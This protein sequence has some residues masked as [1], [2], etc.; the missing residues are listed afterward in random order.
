MTK[1]NKTY[2]CI[3]DSMK[4][5]FGTSGATQQILPLS[6]LC[7]TGKFTICK[8]T[9]DRKLCAR[10]VA[11]GIYPGAEG[12]LICP[13]NGNQCLL[14]IHGGKVCLD[15]TLSENILVSGN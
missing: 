13:E 10:M 1:M 4:R 9:G 11:M 14:K 5:C 3:A 8:V 2:C 7:R 6:K 15:S 12:E